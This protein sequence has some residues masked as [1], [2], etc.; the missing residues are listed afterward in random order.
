LTVGVLVGAWRVAYEH[1]ANVEMPWESDVDRTLF[2]AICR[3]HVAKIFYSVC[4]NGISRKGTAE[5][6]AGV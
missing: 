2:S 1:R 6:A 3:C 4:R 5:A